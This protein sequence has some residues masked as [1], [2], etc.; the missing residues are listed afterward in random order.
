MDPQ[1]TQKKAFWNARIAELR[2]SLLNIAKILNAWRPKEIK[3]LYE[4]ERG[5]GRD[6]FLEDFDNLKALDDET[7]QAMHSHLADYY[8]QLTNTEAYVRVIAIYIGFFSPLIFFISYIFTDKG[9]NRILH[10]FNLI[11][12]PSSGILDFILSIIFALS[13]GLAHSRFS[14]IPFLI[15]Y[16][17]WQGKLSM[18]FVIGIYLGPEV[19]VA[20]TCMTLL[21]NATS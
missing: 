3:K 20:L 8:M 13:M 14:N 10:F 1:T 21:F 19:I 2:N 12:P 4:E 7:K 18:L 16:N 17:K 6:N 9:L 11:L 15:K 5:R